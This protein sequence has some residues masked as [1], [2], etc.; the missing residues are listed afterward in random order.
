ML[1]VQAPVTDGRRASVA[2][3]AAVALYK[4]ILQDVLY[5]RP[6]GT[7]Q[8]LAEALGNQASFIS[9]IANPAYSVPIPARH[10]EAIFDVC[11]FSPAERVRFLDAYARA[12]PHSKPAT[13]RTARWREAMIRVPDLHSPEKNKALD[14]LLAEFARGVV[15]LLKD[16][17]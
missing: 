2:D 17:R 6:S 7:R 11:H 15:R 13:K 9:Q 5:K 8:R 10:V 16:D 4:G 14:D 3:P 1:T 12:H